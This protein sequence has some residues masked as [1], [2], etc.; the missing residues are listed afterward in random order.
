MGIYEYD[1]ESGQRKEI[2]RVENMTRFDVGPGDRIVV[3]TAGNR[4]LVTPAGGSALREIWRAQKSGV[5]TGVFTWAPDGRHLYFRW[6][7][8]ESENPWD[9]ALWRIATTGGPA[10][11]VGLQDGGSD[12]VSPD[13]K[14]IVF[15]GA[16]AGRAEVWAMENMLSTLRGAR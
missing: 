12:R 9:A 10:V 16:G 15:T 14:R 5:L 8:V 1:L 2:Q 3:A 13:G 7:D 4:I 6:E 11:R